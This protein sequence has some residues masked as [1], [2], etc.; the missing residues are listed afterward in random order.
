MSP[1]YGWVWTPGDMQMAAWQPAMVAW[2]QSGGQVGWV[3]L[4]PTDKPGQP[5]VNLRHAFIVSP[6]ATAVGA[7]AINHAVSV[8]NVRATVAMA[9]APAGF[10]SR[11]A[12]AFARSTTPGAGF[13]AGRGPQSVVFDRATRGFVNAP[14]SAGFRAP[15]TSAGARNT[16]SQAP[17][18]MSMPNRGGNGGGFDAGRG[19]YNTQDAQGGLP[20]AN[21]APAS[22][23]PSSAPAAAAPAA[24]APS[25]GA[26]AGHH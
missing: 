12:P 17:A 25:A 8:A 23:A 21:R 13:A 3:P 22:A 10:V 9:H 4:S 2:V 15:E 24:A 19:G 5:P 14:A 26:A 11:T 18:P 7:A 20:S 16:F 6:P 1:M